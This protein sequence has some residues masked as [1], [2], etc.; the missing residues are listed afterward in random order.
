MLLET[1]ASLKTCDWQCVKVPCTQQAV[2]GD[3]VK[4]YSKH[5]IPLEGSG[6]VLQLVKMIYT[7]VVFVGFLQHA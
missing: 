6:N 7:T 2:D 3:I 4:A 1:V 5:R